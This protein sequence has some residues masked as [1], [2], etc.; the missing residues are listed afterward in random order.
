MIHIRDILVNNINI[1]VNNGGFISIPPE[2]NWI[3][4]PEKFNQNKFYLITGGS[5]EITIDDKKYLAK[6]GDWFF[7]PANSMSFYEK[8]NSSDFEKFW[9]HFDIYPT[10]TNLFELL[11]LPHFVRVEDND[12]AIRIFSS[13]KGENEKN[14]VKTLEIKSGIFA[15]LARYITLA[16]KSDAVVRSTSDH[17]IDSV[18]K[19]I[20]SNISGNVSN[21]VLSEICHMHPNHF[22]RFFRSKTG[23]TPAQYVRLRRMD[24][25]RRMLENSDVNVSDTAINCG[26]DDMSYFTKQ[27]RLAYGMTP[28]AYRNNYKKHLLSAEKQLE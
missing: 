11:N 19:Y 10:D 1:N 18:I 2:K 8:N 13:Y 27:F 24:I 3:V 22:T 25:A 28:T 12:E 20:D 7:V 5:C 23:Y 4:K 16:G 9:I 15:L 26:F 6:K 14:F 17:R 21:S